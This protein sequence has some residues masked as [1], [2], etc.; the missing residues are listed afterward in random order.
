MGARLLPITTNRLRY[1]RPHTACYRGNLLMSL[2]KTKTTY[3]ERVEIAR[4]SLELPQ[5]EIAKA[6]NLSTRRIRTILQDP[7]IQSALEQLKAQIITAAAN[8]HGGT[9]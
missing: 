5:D 8:R 9:L 1:A 6:H 3:A 4:K 2:R 7:D